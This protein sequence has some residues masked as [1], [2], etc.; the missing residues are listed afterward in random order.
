MRTLTLI[1]ITPEIRK[2]ART[3]AQAA[4]FTNVYDIIEIEQQLLREY[5]YGHIET[6][7]RYIQ[8][9]KMLEVQID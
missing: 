5:A 7:E 6:L 8:I 1:P 3:I 2:A 9:S 4:P